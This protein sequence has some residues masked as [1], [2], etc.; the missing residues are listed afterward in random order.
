MLTKLGIGFSNSTPI[1]DLL[2]YAL[3]AEQYYLS[4]WLNE[5]YHNRS[6][7]V[8]MA[9]IASRTKTLEL[10]LGIVSPVLRHPF[11]IAMEAG[12]IDEISGGRLILGLGLAAAGAKRHKIDVRTIHPTEVMT[13]SA[14]IIRRMIAGEAVTSTKSFQTLEEGIKL[15]FRPPRREIPL[16]LGAMNPRMLELGGEL[17]DGVLLNYACP[18]SYAKFAIE[19]VIRGSKKRKRAS[20][21]VAAFLL[22]SVAE[23]QGDA[24]EASRRYLPHYLSRAYPISLRYANVSEA[25]ASPVIEALKKSDHERAVSE[26]TDDLIAKLTISGTPDYCVREILK[27][28]D[29]GVDQIIAEQILGPSPREAIEMIG[30]EIAPKVVSR[31]GKHSRA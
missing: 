20:P 10:G 26:V 3:L 15:G 19:H 8:V 5:G 2:D 30:K 12:A 4:F 17:F 27:Y 24:M 22:I 16:Y 18:L 13:E 21:P 1:S 9:A 11:I 23:R 28:S 6:A 31:S 14:W 25:E 29:A 7:P